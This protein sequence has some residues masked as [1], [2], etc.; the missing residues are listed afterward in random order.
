MADVFPFRGDPE[1]LHIG[2]QPL[3]LNAGGAEHGSVV[4]DELA[5]EG[6]G[7]S[8]TLR[9]FLDRGRLFG[10]EA[11]RLGEVVVSCGGLG[12]WTCFR[13]RSTARHGRTAA[14]PTGLRVL[15]GWCLDAH[16]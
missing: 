16:W 14:W 10:C 13:C 8:Q 6:G 11:E 7:A 15:F 12:H 5:D 2:F 3:H 1:V 4:I 9:L